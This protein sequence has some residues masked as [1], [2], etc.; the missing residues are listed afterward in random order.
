MRLMINPADRENV[1]NLIATSRNAKNA[2]SEK[3]N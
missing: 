1:D 2:A 3:E